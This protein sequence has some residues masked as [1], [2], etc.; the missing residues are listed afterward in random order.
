MNLAL[1]LFVLLLACF[2]AA[3]LVVN[4][5]RAIVTNLVS[6]I[7]GTVP[8]YVA[9]GT[10]AGTTGATDTTLFTESADETRATGTPTRIN[11]TTTNDTLQVVGTMTVVTGNKTITNAGLFDAV[12]SGN[13]FFKTDFAGLPLLIGDALQL[14]FKVTYS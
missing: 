11:V 14:T 5:G 12:S 13:M 7:G 4:G 3:T 9:W 6:G 8:K 2:P 1:V 10:G